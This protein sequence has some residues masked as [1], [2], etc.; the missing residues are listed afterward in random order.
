M[1]YPYRCLKCAHNFEIVKAVKDVHL[2]H[3]C[4]ACGHNETE[5][6]FTSKLYFNGA[7]VQH[8]EYNPGL[9][10]VTKNKEH[11]SEIARQK[12]LVEVGNETPDTLHKETV[13]KREQER[14]REWDAL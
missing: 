3:D 10:C 2:T 13:V 9:G 12:G 1:I 14:A 7:K 11:R 5:R 8:A 6:V 4:E